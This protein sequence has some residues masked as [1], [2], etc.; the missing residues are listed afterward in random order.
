MA[1]RDK[2]FEDE[3][4]TEPG[5]VYGHGGKVAASEIT[6]TGSTKLPPDGN[7]SRMFSPEPLGTAEELVKKSVLSSFATLIPVDKADGTVINIPVLNRHQQ[8]SEFQFSVGGWSLDPKGTISERM[9][10]LLIG[11]LQK[12]VEDD[13]KVPLPDTYT[14]VQAVHTA[15]RDAAN[16]KLT[17]YALILSDESAEALNSSEDAV[18]DAVDYSANDSMR[19]AG[20]P[21]ITSP[22]I[23]PGEMYIINKETSLIGYRDMV[24]RVGNQVG[25]GA[26]F[27]P[28]A[29]A[30]GA[31]DGCHFVHY[32]F[33]DETND[34]CL[35]CDT[36]GYSYW[37]GT[38]EEC[39]E[40]LHAHT[41]DKVHF[42]TRAAWP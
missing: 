8:F 37:A 4:L 23:K 13:S 14:H 33:S 17:N 11:L 28:D 30:Y 31:A 34:F 18:K 29:L 5:L 7:L 22:L 10:K 41:E 19:Y 40:R 26:S 9:D 39:V 27:T 38:E 35:D 15:L 24:V 2:K 20:I 36:C 12:S 16:R 42:L 32:E 6:H 21:L 1:K 25:V 3:I